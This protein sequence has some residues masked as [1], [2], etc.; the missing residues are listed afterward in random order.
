MAEY[1]HSLRVEAQAVEVFGFVADVGNLPDY[2]PTVRRAEAQPGERVRVAG[3]ASGHEYDSDG[4][5]R[6]DD[7]RRRMEWG[8]D[9]ENEYRGWL[10]VKEADG[11]KSC[12][13]TV[14]L[15]FTPRP[16]QARQFEEQTGDRDRTVRQGIET[17][18]ASI[19][20]VC[21]GR[22]GKIEYRSA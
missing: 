8:S 3:N 4:F 21:E 2:L 15:S 9:G 10:E 11:G 22:G 12:D 16:D 7:Q 17:A 19:K 13:V 14:H 1:E 5:F 6:V 20:N 18:L